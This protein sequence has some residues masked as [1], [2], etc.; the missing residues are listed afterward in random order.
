MGAGQGIRRAFVAIELPG[1]VLA[2]LSVRVRAAQR[3]EGAARLRWGRQGWHATLSFLGEVDAPDPLIEVVAP[4]LRDR[5]PPIVRLGGAGAFP[6]VRRG[7]VLWV[8]FAEGPDALG[9]L[10]TCV[11][12]ATAPLGFETETRRFRPHVTVARSGRAHDLRPLANALGDEPIGPAWRVADAVLLSS[13]T[14]RD[15]ARYTEVCR[16]PLQGAAG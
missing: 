13:E 8:G 1:P 3:V 4:A 7:T 6:G 11:A 15:G 2:D 14:D 9:E 12:R 5:V 16:F 10:A